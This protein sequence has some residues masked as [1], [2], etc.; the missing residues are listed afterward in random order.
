[1]SDINEEIVI[2]EHLTHIVVRA[3]DFNGQEG[4]IRLAHDE[5]DRLIGDL[6]AARMRLKLNQIDEENKRSKRLKLGT[7]MRT[8]DIEKK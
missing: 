5:L 4:I 8:I 3:T 1:M 6:Q 7:S 2:H